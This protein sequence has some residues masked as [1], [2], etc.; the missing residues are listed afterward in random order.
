MSN[1]RP[2]LG[3]LLV[4]AA[5]VIWSWNFIV[6]RH[7][8]GS[9]PPVTLAFLRWTTAVLLLLP[10]AWSMLWRDRQLVLRHLPYLAVAGFLGVTM[11]NTLLYIAGHTTNAV[12]MALVAISSP[13]FIVICARIFLGEPFT[14]RRVVGVS[15][16][17]IGVILL[18]TR[19]NLATLTE[20]TFS[21]GDLWMLLA[22]VIFAVYSILVRFKP[23]ALNQT[24]FLCSSF[25]LGLIF[26]LPWLGWELS[27]HKAVILS[28]DVIASILYLGVG[29]SLASYYCW[30]SAIAIIGPARAGFVYY[31][32]PLFSGV[33][34]SLVL[35]EPILWI[36]FVSGLLIV[37]GIIVATRETGDQSIASN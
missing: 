25:I 16:A 26:M 3:Y 24:T 20:L 31:S 9:V 4:L 19:G 30:N 33:E 2:F 10:F 23:V 13:V 28:T 32:L 36:H 17:T 11:F 15:T 35:Q 6:A 21:V 29:P 5:T 7:L 27:E 22:A 37:A 12:N 18:I 1:S 8:V 14:A 34:A